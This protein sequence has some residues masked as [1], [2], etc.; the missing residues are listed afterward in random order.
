MS[1]N[2][3][4]YISGKLVIKNIFEVQR[5]DRDLR[6]VNAVARVAKGN[7]GKKLKEQARLQPTRRSDLA[8]IQ[9]HAANANVFLGIHG[10]RAVNI[11]P[12]LAGNL[13]WGEFAFTIEAIE[14]GEYELFIVSE[15]VGPEEW[16][17]IGVF[18]EFVILP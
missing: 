18:D 9:Q 10:T 11:H 17:D 4:H 14:P 7:R 16:R 13:L 5:P 15:G 12:I 2:R 8:D 3:H 6:F 1:N